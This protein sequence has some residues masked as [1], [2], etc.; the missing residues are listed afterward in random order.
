MLNLFTSGMISTGK[1]S[2]SSSKENKIQDIE[3]SD[4][5]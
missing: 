3:V 5:V 4:T 2:S 1:L